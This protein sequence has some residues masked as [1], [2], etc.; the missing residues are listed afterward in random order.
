MK[1]SRPGIDYS[2]GLRNENGARYNVDESVMGGI[3]YGVIPIHDVVQAWSDSSEAIYP[4]SESCDDDENESCDDYSEPSEFVLND[5]EYQATQSADDVDI[6]VIKSPFYTFAQFCS[7]CAPG[8]CY[9]R[10]PVDP[11]NTDNRCY[12]FGIDFFDADISP[13]P[14][15]IW[16]VDTGEKIY[17]PKNDGDE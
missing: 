1:T 8:A 17:E 15:P 3:R 14:Y 16:R 10:N 2:H 5:G 7:P 13:C 12:C 9:L 11:I 6:F 4:E